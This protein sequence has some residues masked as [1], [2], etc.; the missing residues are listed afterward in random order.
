LCGC[1]IEATKRRPNAWLPLKNKKKYFFKKK[2]NE[3]KKL[4]NFS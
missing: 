1:Q 3:K 4:A 2:E